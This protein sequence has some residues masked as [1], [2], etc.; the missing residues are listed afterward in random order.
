MS[1]HVSYQKKSGEL[2]MKINNLISN[3]PFLKIQL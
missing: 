1:K 3:N 2:N